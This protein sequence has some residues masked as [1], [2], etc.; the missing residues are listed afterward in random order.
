MTGLLNIW[1][2]VVLAV[3]GA[4]VAAASGH[5]I[6]QAERVCASGSPRSSSGW[7]RSGTCSSGRLAVRQE[8]HAQQVR[9]WE[10]R[11][12]AFDRQLQWYAV[13]LPDGIDRIDVAGGTLAGWSALLT[14]VA[15]PRLSAGGDVT[16]LD[17]TEGTVARD[18]LAVARRSGV[19]AAGL[20]AAR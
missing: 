15:A 2:T 3:L 18:L 12:E 8:Q 11:R 9:A 17:L 16:V 6:R 5:R 10:S 1:L 4:A 7:P 14:M 19:A 20:G 13:S